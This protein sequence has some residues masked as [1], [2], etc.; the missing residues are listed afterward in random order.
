MSEP[1]QQRSSEP[2]GPA[3]TIRCVVEIPKGSRN[4]YEYDHA[5]GGLVL[6]RFL[7]SSV[8]YP[9]D[10]GFIPDTLSLDGDPLDVLICVSEPTFP[11]CVVFARPIALLEMEDERG[12][13]PHVLCVPWRIPAGT[14]W[15]GSQTCRHSCALRSAI[16]SPPT[17][18]STPTGA[19]PCRDG[20]I[21]TR[22]L[23]RSSSH[24]VAARPTARIGIGSSTPPAARHPPERRG[25]PSRTGGPWPWPPA[26]RSH[27]TPNCS[28]RTRL[29]G[30]PCRRRSRENVFIIGGGP[31]MYTHGLISG[32]TAAI[33]RST[34]S[35]PSVSALTR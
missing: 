20:V 1:I 25:A 27:R 10:Y 7:S 23:T 26:R 13:D 19:R 30:T 17:R 6:D 8:V 31:H 18:I 15:S 35:R 33:T 9:T 5:V 11:G 3:F 28:H 32:D 2:A 22:R 16:S 24:V 14:R 12:V 21:A 34:V 29:A 4:K